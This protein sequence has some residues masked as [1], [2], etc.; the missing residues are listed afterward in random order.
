MSQEIKIAIIAASS[1]IL[2][3][4][5]SQAT[6]LLISCIER[7][8]QKNILLRQKYEE[9]M[10]HFS[11]SLEW[12]RYL[13]GC[14]TQSEVFALA[15]STDARKALSLCLL[16][17]PILARPA[18]DYILAQQVYYASIITSFKEDGSFTAGGQAILKNKVSHETAQKA[19]FEK[20][21]NFE[22]LIISNANEYTKA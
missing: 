13:N 18:N 12:I 22:N 3:A 20:K 16:Y 9:M 11:A 5:I 10:F 17:F 14:T 6:T 21:E 1:A 4:I 2:G 15:Q 7:K 19:L 8:R